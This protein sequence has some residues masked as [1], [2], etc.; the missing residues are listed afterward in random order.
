MLTIT[1]EPRLEARCASSGSCSPKK[2]RKIGSLS[3][4]WRGVRIS[5][6][7]KMF[8]TE[9]IAR[10]TASWYDALAAARRRAAARRAGGD[11]AIGAPPRAGSHSGRNVETTNSSATAIGRRLREDEPEPTHGERAQVYE[12]SLENISA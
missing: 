2:R 11:R 5:F 3:S 8:T 9:G 6:E 4:G 1:P 12:N 7:V 10:C